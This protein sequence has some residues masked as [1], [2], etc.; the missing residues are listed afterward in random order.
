MTSLGRPLPGL[1]NQQ[2]SSSGTEYSIWGTGVL[3]SQVEDPVGWECL[4]TKFRASSNG[5][6]VGI[7]WQN[8]S[9]T[10]NAADVALFQG[11]TN[12][13]GTRTVSGTTSSGW[14]RMN[15]A[16]PVAITA[17]T[18]YTAVARIGSGAGSC[19]F[20]I[21]NNYFTS[22][23]VTNGPLEAV[24]TSVSSNGVYN[25]NT[26]MTQPTLNYLDSSYF[27]DVVYTA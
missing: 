1:Y 13:S 7:R 22:A 3:G 11:S 10:W 4:G 21:S 2:A 27:I 5:Y 19:R 17:S 9:A 8:I 20:Y 6:I 16:S 25:E 15:F 14:Q 12:V 23:G 26:T 24:A 18:V